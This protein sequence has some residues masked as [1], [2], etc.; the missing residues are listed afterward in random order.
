MK[1]VILGLAVATMILSCKET[2]VETVKEETTTESVE[3]VTHSAL[4]CL[5][6]AIEAIISTS[7]I[8]FPPN[9]VLWSL[10]SFGKTLDV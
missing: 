2:K 10:K 5:V 8:N 1:K 7:L 4:E 3:A 9:N 6:A